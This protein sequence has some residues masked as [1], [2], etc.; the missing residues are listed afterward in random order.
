MDRLERG[1]PESALVM[2]SCIGHDDAVMERFYQLSS[3]H[4]SAMTR[5]G[6][7]EAMGLGHCL[8]SSIERQAIS[9]RCEQ[10]ASGHCLASSLSAQRYACCCAQQVSV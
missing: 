8:I 7:E 2:Q 6:V 4:P 5:V 1:Q 9:W 3:C 10:R